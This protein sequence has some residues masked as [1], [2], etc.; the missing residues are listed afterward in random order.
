MP[1]EEATVF[2]RYQLNTD[3]KS[4]MVGILSSIDTIAMSGFN[5][6]FNIVFSS[7]FYNY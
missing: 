7:E 2:L 6:A 4:L 5:L 1:E 3:T